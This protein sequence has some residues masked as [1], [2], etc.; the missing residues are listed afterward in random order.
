MLDEHVA[1]FADEADATCELLHGGSSPGARFAR[2]VT[3][4][5]P[6]TRRH[7]ALASTD[8][9]WAGYADGWRPGFRSQPVTRGGLE[10]ARA[11]RL[12]AGVATPAV[13]VMKPFRRR[14]SRR[15]AAFL[16]SA[17]GWTAV[18]PPSSDLRPGGGGRRAAGDTAIARRLWTR[19][20]EG[21]ER[22]GVPYEAA[23]KERL[24]AASPT[25]SPRRSGE[26]AGYLRRMRAAPR[27]SACAQRSRSAGTIRTC[28][29][30]REV[31]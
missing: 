1:A 11:S 16:R 2:A 20:L 25:M 15:L 3:S 7:G 24:A 29:L 31:G 21:F 6:R 17:V 28:G 12:R 5:R 18:W 19:A 23:R 8:P 30:C 9:L 13:I 4:G 27:P 10:Q 14:R 26:R 22:V